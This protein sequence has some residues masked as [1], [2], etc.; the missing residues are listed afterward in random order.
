MAFANKVPNYIEGFYNDFEIIS[1]VKD[2]I[3]LRVSCPHF[4]NI[5]VIIPNAS[6]SVMNVNGFALTSMVKNFTFTF[7]ANKMS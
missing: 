4:G 7:H 2:F 3:A 1:C 5:I 6:H